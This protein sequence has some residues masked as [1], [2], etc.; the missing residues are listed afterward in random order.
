VLC[1][2]RCDLKGF[3]KGCERFHPV[4]EKSIFKVHRSQILEACLSFR[5][6]VAH[7]IQREPAI[8][9]LNCILES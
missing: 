8:F 1:K 4:K 3:C 5:Q 9:N 6:R 2:V 7:V